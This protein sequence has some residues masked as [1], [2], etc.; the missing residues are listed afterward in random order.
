MVGS[1][2]EA[3][4]LLKSPRASTTTVS[5]LYRELKSDAGRLTAD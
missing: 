5:V 3:G 2:S 1:A 4:Q